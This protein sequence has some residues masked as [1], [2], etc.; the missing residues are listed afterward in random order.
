MGL[1]IE[2]KT[3]KTESNGFITIS[4]NFKLSEKESDLFKISNSIALFEE[5]FQ[6]IKDLKSLLAI[7][8]NLTPESIKGLISQRGRIKDLLSSSLHNFR[9]L[10]QEIKTLEL[11]LKDLEQSLDIDIKHNLHPLND[12][13]TSD[14][15][16][17]E[18]LKREFKNIAHFLRTSLLKEQGEHHPCPV[19][20]Q[21][22]NPE[23]LKGKI[24]DIQEQTPSDLKDPKLKEVIELCAK[25]QDY[26]KKLQERDTW[27]NEFG[28]VEA[29]EREIKELAKVLFNLQSLQGIVNDIELQIKQETRFGNDEARA[30]ETNTATINIEEKVEIL[31]AKLKAKEGTIKQSISQFHTEVILKSKLDSNLNAQKKIREQINFHQEETKGQRD[32]TLENNLSMDETKKRVQKIEELLKSNQ[33]SKE[34]VDKKNSELIELK[35]KKISLEKQSKELETILKI[36]SASLKSGCGMPTPIHWQENKIRTETPEPPD[37]QTWENVSQEWLKRDQECIKVEAVLASMSP[38]IKELSDQ[39]N[40]HKKKLQETEESQK[41]VTCTKKVIEFLDYKNAPRKLLEAIVTDLFE[42]TNKL[43]ENLQVDI[44]LKL[45]KNLEF[46]TLQSRSGKW[47][48]QKTERLGFGKGAI[49]GICFRLACQKLLLP[50]TGFLILDEPTANVDLKRKG[51]FKLFLQNLSQESN[52]KSGQIVLIEHDE[53]VVELC[54]TKLDIKE[55]TT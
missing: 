8:N 18:L 51:L 10:S 50:E 40:L 13:N 30:N 33:Q 7:K 39:T 47:I 31:I 3:I 37:D 52:T 16:K 24:K 49:L 53:D 11:S 17:S 55:T 43:A 2:E 9:T 45:G 1:C 28:S 38:R 14:A 4:N 15:L 41:R 35:S 5:K 36:E 20:L 42:V 23:E 46:L 21:I 48:E 6:K 19:C 34:I 22:I 25:L 12:T 27:I 54:T 26:N 32:P 29:I 44:K